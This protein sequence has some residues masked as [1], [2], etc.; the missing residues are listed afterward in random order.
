MHDSPP[1][2]LP[3]HCTPGDDGRH[4]KRHR[5]EQ[6]PRH[7]CR[8]LQRAAA[9]ASRGRRQLVFS[10]VVGAVAL[11]VSF[12]MTSLAWIPLQPMVL[13]AF[14]F[15]FTGSSLS[16]CGGGVPVPFC[17]WH[18]METIHAWL[19]RAETGLIGQSPTGTVGKRG[20]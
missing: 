3:A 20:F 12:S 15:N 4:R 19:S 9:G 14:F 16:L 5:R 6:Q 2:A 13:D 1:L 7:P 18:G 8:V 17:G 10:F 11:D